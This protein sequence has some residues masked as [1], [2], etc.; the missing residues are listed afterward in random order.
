[1]N[2]DLQNRPARPLRSTIAACALLCV[3]L[4]LRGALAQGGP[5]ARAA[6]GDPLEQHVYPPDLIMEHQSAIGLRNDQRQGL[7][8]EV[9]QLQTDVVPLQFELSEAAESLARILSTP[10]VDEA[11]AIAEAE[12]ITTL[13]AQVKKRHLVLLIR[14]KNLLTE[15]QQRQLDAFRR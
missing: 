15:E 14:I 9:Q 7:V 6:G 8:A 11:A 13:E 4:P 12:R 2:R 10:R 5:G 3:L 1:M